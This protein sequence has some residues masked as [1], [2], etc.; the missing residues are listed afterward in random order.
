MEAELSNNALVS[1][2]AFPAHSNFIKGR[3][4]WA[5]NILADEHDNTQRMQIHLVDDTK[6]ETRETYHFPTEAS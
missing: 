2:F 4:T 1:K 3:D 5:H 6:L